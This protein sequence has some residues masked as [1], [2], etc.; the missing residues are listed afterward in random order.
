MAQ[1]DQLTPELLTQPS[2]AL[3]VPQRLARGRLEQATD[4]AQQAGLARPIGALNPQQLTGR[5]GAADTAKQTATT[6][7]ATKVPQCQHAVALPIMLS[8]QARLFK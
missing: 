6:A 2:H 4:D 5:N 8:I 1:I 3:A 7:C